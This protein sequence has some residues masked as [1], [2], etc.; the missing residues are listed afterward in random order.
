MAKRIS[1]DQQIE[2]VERELAERAKVYPR[3]MSSGR[4]RPS[5]AEFHVARME[6]VLRTLKWVKANEAKLRAAAKEP[7]EAPDRCPDCGSEGQCPPGCPSRLAD[8]TP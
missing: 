2:E 1:L 3:L 7:A 5:V 6:A 4:M 8:A